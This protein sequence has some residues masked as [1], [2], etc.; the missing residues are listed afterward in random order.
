MNDLFDVKD[1]LTVYAG[2]EMWT[3]KRISFLINLDKEKYPNIIAKNSD[4]EIVA[5]YNIYGWTCNNWEV[6][7]DLTIAEF[8]HV[9]QKK[10]DYIIL[11]DAIAKTY[12]C[13]FCISQVVTPT[14]KFH[15]DIDSFK[16]FQIFLNENFV[17]GH[18]IYNSIK[19][20]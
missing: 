13:L 5:V 2:L 20:S 15:V 14:F 17:E 1:P 7:K 3:Q 4:S 19:F 11:G 10:A 8:M 9:C 12:E 18:K 16:E 6:E